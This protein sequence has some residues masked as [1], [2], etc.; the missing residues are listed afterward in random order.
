M[1]LIILILTQSFNLITPNECHY[2]LKNL[3]FQCNISGIYK[4]MYNCSNHT[5]QQKLYNHYFD[6]NL[7]LTKMYKIT[8]KF[9][10]PKIIMYH[11]RTTHD[12]GLPWPF[13]TD[14]W[15]NHINTF[16]ILTLHSTHTNHK[17]VINPK[18]I[19]PIGILFK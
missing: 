14:N 10:I 11:C 13:K 3:P 8:N 5:E 16:K 17:T 12:Q 1:Y 7:E 9:G 2:H 4:L 19:H 6:D 18:I 15:T